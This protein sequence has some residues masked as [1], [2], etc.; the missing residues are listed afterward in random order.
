MGCQFTCPSIKKYKRNSKLNM[1][2]CVELTRVSRVRA[3]GWCSAHPVYDIL[4]GAW[5]FCD[6]SCG[7]ILIVLPMTG[8]NQTQFNEIAFQ[9]TP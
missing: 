6:D 9:A 4:V 3:R 2:K 7:D 8:S 1:E 5:L